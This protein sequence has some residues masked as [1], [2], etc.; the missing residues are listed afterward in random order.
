MVYTPISLEIMR[1]AQA[2]TVVSFFFENIS[3]QCTDVVQ[4]RR[5]SRL[6]IGNQ[7]MH[8][9]GPEMDAMC[10]GSDAIER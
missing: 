2:D 3:I 1:F 10:R 9:G 8:S 7:T 4:I 5:A 6:Y